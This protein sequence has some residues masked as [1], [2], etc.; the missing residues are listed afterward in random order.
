MKDLVI[1]S[2][3]QI[4][5]LLKDRFGEVE[6]LSERPVFLGSQSMLSLG[7][8]GVLCVF[9]VENGKKIAVQVPLGVAVVS[10]DEAA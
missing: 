1:P 6:L 10:Q 5:A 3:E 8:A 7:L 4:L 9:Q 2:T